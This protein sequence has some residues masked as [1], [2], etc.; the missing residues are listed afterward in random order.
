MVKIVGDTTSG[1]P[2]VFAKA[3]GIPIMPQVIIFGETSYLEGLEITY[4]TF[5]DKLRGATSLPKTA[6]PPPELFMEVFE[7]CAQ[8]GEPAV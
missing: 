1:L 4:D 8:D 3:H 5:M 6:A 2:D 7:Q